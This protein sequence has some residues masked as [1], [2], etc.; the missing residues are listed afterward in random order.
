MSKFAKNRDV[1]KTKKARL[2]SIALG[3]T[4]WAQSQ[5]VGTTVD[6]RKTRLKESQRPALNVHTDNR[7]TWRKPLKLVRRV[8]RG[9]GLPWQPQKIPKTHD[10][11]MIKVKLGKERVKET[12]KI[13]KGRPKKGKIRKCLNVNIKKTIKFSLVKKVCS[14]SLVNSVKI[15]K[16]TS[17]EKFS[18]LDKKKRKRESMKIFTREEEEKREERKKILKEVWEGKRKVVPIKYIPIKLVIESSLSKRAIQEMLEDML[19][20]GWR[21]IGPTATGS[22]EHEIRYVYI[23]WMDEREALK[24]V[25]CAP[26]RLSYMELSEAKRN[27]DQ[28][29]QTCQVKNE[30]MKTSNRRLF[31]DLT[32]MEKK[33]KDCEWGF[34][35]KFLLYPAEGVVAAMNAEAINNSL[36][37]FWVIIFS[38][39]VIIFKFNC[40]YN[41]GKRVRSKGI[42]HTDMI[43]KYYK[44]ENVSRY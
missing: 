28:L 12:I 8:P 44:N 35:E 21:K 4:G 34:I 14:K 3:E 40:G 43:L 42:G 32:S 39:S 41:I 16:L 37:I 31:E 13:R 5:P 23:I 25:T 27:K 38:K 22:M 19:S 36:Y 29:L 24:A 33:L 30:K 11:E 15:F 7:R 6:N 17:S 10:K 1:I 26:E 9:P 20:I 18:N 2:W